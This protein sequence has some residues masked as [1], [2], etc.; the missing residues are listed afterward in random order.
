MLFTY[1]YLAEAVRMRARR[2]NETAVERAERL[3]SMHA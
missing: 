1:Y 2:D 3:R